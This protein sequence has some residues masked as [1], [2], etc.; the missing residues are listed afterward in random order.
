MYQLTFWNKNKNYQKKHFFSSFY[1]LIFKIQTQND[2][3]KIYN[4]ILVNPLKMAY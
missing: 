1:H 3:T 4:L 2:F